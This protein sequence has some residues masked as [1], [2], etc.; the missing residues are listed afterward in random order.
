MERDD[1]LS[2][3]NQR[4]G[5]RSTALIR[6]ASN[7][8]AAAIGA[9]LSGL[10]RDDRLSILNQ[11]D[12]EGSTALIRAASNGIAAAIGAL[13]SDLER[14][15]RLSILNQRDGEGTALM[16]A[17][18]NGH[19]AAIY[20]LLAGFPVP[21]R[22]AAFSQIIPGYVMIAAARGHIAVV[23]AVLNYLP[24]DRRV[25]LVRGMLDD[26]VNDFFIAS[27]GNG[28]APL[29]E[30]NINTLEFLFKTGYVSEV[31][32]DT[33]IKIKILATKNRMPFSVFNLLANA[34]N[35]E[36]YNSLLGYFRDKSNYGK[37]DIHINQSY[38]DQ[39]LRMLR[40]DLEATKTKF[41]QVE[42]EL[43]NKLVNIDNSF[44]NGS[45]Q[46]ILRRLDSLF[47][48][49]NDINELAAHFKR[50]SDKLG[51][52][53]YA[54]SERPIVDRINNYV[55]KYDLSDGLI[56]QIFSKSDEPLTQ[57]NLSTGIGKGF[58]S[59]I[60]SRGMDRLRDQNTPSA[61]S[62]TEA[63]DPAQPAGS[64]T[65]NVRQRTE[66]NQHPRGVQGPQGRGGRSI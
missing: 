43:S 66:G 15:D 9:L 7:G 47:F 30:K 65:R 56:K 24:Q 54:D 3:L 42:A 2:I 17:A 10:R 41:T 14:D 55:R 37:N 33:K 51:Q 64:N 19:A 6:A 50:I 12:G 62:G 23:K 34:V 28:A 61:P 38:D 35:A 20:A 21:A 49:I 53:L 40:R 27:A 29:K 1:R 57:D 18:P 60:F 63:E 22:E 39:L 52:I 46:I 32:E 26:L 4:D 59:V 5:E 45:Y 44:S 31:S 8:H 16:H 58:R 11:R 36:D 13:L 25:K 48:W